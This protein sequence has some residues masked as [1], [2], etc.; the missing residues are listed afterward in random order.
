[1]ETRLMPSPRETA[2][3]DTT[4][5][6]DAF[7]LEHLFV[8]GKVCLTCTDLDR[9]VVGGVVPTSGPLELGNYDAL[10]AE[11]F[12][13]RRELGILNI[14]GIVGSIIYALVGAVILLLLIGLIK[15]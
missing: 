8:P 11:F 12:C 14:G 7:L 10:K 1:M 3:L 9:A 13:Q 15:R 2:V 6:R 4:D 5:L